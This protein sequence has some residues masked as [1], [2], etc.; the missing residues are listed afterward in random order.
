M[1]LLIKFKTTPLS[2]VGSSHEVFEDTGLSSDDCGLPGKARRCYNEFLV[3]FAWDELVE[4]RLN[5][6]YEK[7]RSVKIKIFEINRRHE[8][9]MDIIDVERV[10]RSVQ[11]FS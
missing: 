9:L 4:V 8:E 11:T 2:G 6:Y 1:F 3:P 10:L 5:R 7:W